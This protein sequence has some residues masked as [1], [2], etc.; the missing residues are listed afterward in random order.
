MR[1]PNIVLAC[2]PA[3]PLQEARSHTRAFFASGGKLGREADAVFVSWE[4]A[5]AIGHI[6]KACVRGVGLV[7]GRRTASHD[8]IA[9]RVADFEHALAAEVA[10]RHIAGNPLADVNVLSILT[11][12]LESSC[13]ILR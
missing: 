10:G 12:Q 4:A 3:C 13:G 1:H 6:S 2:F 5:S 11:C 8:L 7:K 9:P